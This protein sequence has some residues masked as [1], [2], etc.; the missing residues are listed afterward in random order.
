V[1]TETAASAYFVN[2][3]QYM[4]HDD[5]QGAVCGPFDCPAYTVDFT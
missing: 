1:S 5:T 4:A 3:V 2:I